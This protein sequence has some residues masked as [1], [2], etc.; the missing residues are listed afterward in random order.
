MHR[1]SNKIHWEIDLDLC[2]P[3]TAL[4]L[5]VESMI[6]ILTT[7]NYRLRLCPNQTHII[8]Q[9]ITA[10]IM[11]PTGYVMHQYIGLNF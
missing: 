3:F 11:I 4:V 10:D 2:L 5:M 1:F 8:K 9:H 6:Y 7:K